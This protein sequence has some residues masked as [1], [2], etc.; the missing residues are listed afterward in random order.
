MICTFYSESFW[1]VFS[2]CHSIKGVILVD[3]SATNILLESSI[4]CNPVSELN[5]N[6]HNEVAVVAS[7]FPQVSAV[8]NHWLSLSLRRKWSSLRSH[9][10]ILTLPEDFAWQ[11]LEKA[12][13]YLVVCKISKSFW[14]L[15]LLNIWAQ[16]W[17]NLSRPTPRSSRRTSG[18]ALSPWRS[19]KGQTLSAST[20]STSTKRRLRRSRKRSENCNDRTQV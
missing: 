3:L 13:G 12:A 10:Q 5:R 7:S 11:S 18:S 9:L 16:R 15:E 14:K 1:F 8:T 2:S 6:H 19:S 20:S 4:A 17:R